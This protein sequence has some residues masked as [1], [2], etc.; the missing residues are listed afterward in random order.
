LK[1]AETVKGV[2][3]ARDMGVV[4]KGTLVGTARL[5]AL[6]VGN[7]VE[8]IR[9]QGNLSVSRAVKDMM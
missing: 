6:G 4:F 7:N 2:R 9:V 5:A 3:S 8:A 1:M